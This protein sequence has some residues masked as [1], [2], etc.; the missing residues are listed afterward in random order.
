MVEK[1]KPR[2]AI[3]CPRCGE[4]DPNALGRAWSSVWWFACSVCAYVWGDREVVGN[5]VAVPTV[6]TSPASVS[7]RRAT[8]A[9]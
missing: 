2:D 4:R 9:D 3:R 7:A 6:V 1:S 5:A 8:H